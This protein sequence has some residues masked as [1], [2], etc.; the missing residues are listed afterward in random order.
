MNT[1]IQKELRKSGIEIHYYN[2]LVRFCRDMLT[3]TDLAELLHETFK[4]YHFELNFIRDMLE[5]INTR[6]AI[7]IINQ[8][9]NF[10]KN[11][12]SKSKDFIEFIENTKI[13]TRSHSRLSKERELELE[14]RSKE[15]FDKKVY[16]ESLP[17]K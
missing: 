14:Y 2:S 1:L 10:A 17:K 6:P 16:Y 13:L 11:N 4:N 5:E 9:D 15:I 12:R 7:K 8:I 3:N